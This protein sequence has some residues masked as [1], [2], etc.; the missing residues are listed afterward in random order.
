MDP[1]F[2]LQQWNQSAPSGWLPGMP[3]PWFPYQGMPFADFGTMQQHQSIQQLQQ[4]QQAHPQHQLHEMKPLQ[5]LTSIHPLNYHHPLPAITPPGTENELLTTPPTSSAYSNVPF[6]FPPQNQLDKPVERCP[7]TAIPLPAPEADCPPSLEE[8]TTAAEDGVVGE[9]R[10]TDS[11]SS[12]STEPS[13]LPPAL[14]KEK[15]EGEK[16]GRGQ[17]RKRSEGKDDAKD[18]ADETLDAPSSPSD[19]VKVARIGPPLRNYFCKVTGRLSVV[20]AQIKYDVSCEE[21]LRRTTMPECLNRSHIGPLLRRGKIRGCGDD[22]Q[23]LLELR[24]LSSTSHINRKRFPLT[25][26]SAFLEQ[27][28]IRFTEDHKDLLHAH[29]PVTAITR[30]ILR[31]IDNPNDLL[32]AIEDAKHAKNAAAHLESL[33][34]GWTQGGGESE[35]DSVMRSPLKALA[36]STHLLGTEEL[37][38]FSRLFTRLVSTLIQ[39]LSA[40]MERA[41][42]AATNHPYA[43]LMNQFPPDMEWAE[44]PTG[45]LVHKPDAAEE[46]QGSRCFA[47]IPGRLTLT[48]KKYTVNVAELYRRVRAPE[49]LNL[50][51]L[52]SQLRKGKTKDNGNSLRDELANEGINIDQG[53]RKSAKITLFTA[54]LEEEAI[55]VAKDVGDV[56]E[57]SNLIGTI[58]DTLTLGVTMPHD[59]ITRQNAFLAASRI[60]GSIADLILALRLPVADRHPYKIDERAYTIFNYCQ[61]TH[62]YGPDSALQWM[63]TF[64]KLFD[65]AYRSLPEVQ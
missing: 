55:Q 33:V 65:L 21:I 53:R 9:G 3:H 32:T 4:P 6:D 22:L 5:P 20:G 12:P 60:A 10:E 47:E 49:S 18:D 24:G 59:I 39:E 26:L 50:S 44:T 61:L 28:A 52:G 43:M 7:T 37:L 41:Q 58:R 48:N 57:S 16:K 63:G 15:G 1:F 42:I 34:D 14:A 29:F 23:E 25:S 8:E 38:L 35:I 11:S 27:E 64:R 2:P 45:P 19:D 36:L 51:L 56:V 30:M 46:A 62:G 31:K 54:L 17:K 13:G 40:Q